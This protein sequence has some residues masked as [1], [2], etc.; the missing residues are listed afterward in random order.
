MSLEYCLLSAKEE[1]ENIIGFFD[2]IETYTI[3]ASWI[4]HYLFII[5][6]SL[7][8]VTYRIT[9]LEGVPRAE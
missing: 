4:N 8:R 3:T 2:I 1:N 5:F 7:L 6:F 9:A